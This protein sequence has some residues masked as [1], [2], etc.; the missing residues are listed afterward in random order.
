[1][2]FS[3]FPKLKIFIPTCRSSISVVS[4]APGRHNDT[5]ANL[6]RSLFQKTPHIPSSNFSILGWK[7]SNGKY[8][9][10]L[11]WALPCPPI[12]SFLCCVQNYIIHTR[13]FLVSKLL[14]KKW[15]KLGWKNLEFGFLSCL[16]SWMCHHQGKCW[17]QLPAITATSRTL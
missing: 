10:S 1:M 7:E 12:L 15:E 2:Y 3:V 16:V 11:N 6:P 9:F 8:V 13:N 14:V 17:P 4:V 5:V